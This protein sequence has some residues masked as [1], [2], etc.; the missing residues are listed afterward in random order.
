[1]RAQAEAAAAGDARRRAYL[2]EAKQD[3][4]VQGAF[5]GLVDHE[6][7]V[8]TKVG[9]GKKQTRDGVFLED[10]VPTDATQKVLQSCPENSGCTRD[11]CTI[12]Q[13][14]TAKVSLRLLLLLLLSLD[15]RDPAAAAAGDARGHPAPTWSVAFQ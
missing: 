10:G 1:M 12:R 9:L 4:C 3:V 13:H 5:V 14:G 8:G 15:V 6:H 11:A 7:R 2:D